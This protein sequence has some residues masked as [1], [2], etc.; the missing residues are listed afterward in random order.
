VNAVL[1]E[2][3]SRGLVELSR[4]NTRVIDPVGLAK[5]AR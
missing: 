5:R 2:A 4:G 1:R 3:Q